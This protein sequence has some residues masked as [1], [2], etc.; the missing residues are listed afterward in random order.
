VKECNRLHGIFCS[1][2]NKLEELFNA[3]KEKLEPLYNLLD[4]CETKVEEF[5]L[6]EKKPNIKMFIQLFTDISDKYESNRE[7]KDAMDGYKVNFQLVE[8]LEIH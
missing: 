4:W 1:E 6:Q 2:F 7:L 8:M 5:G 3:T